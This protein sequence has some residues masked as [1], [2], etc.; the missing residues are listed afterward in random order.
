MITKEKLDNSIFY[1]PIQETSKYIYPSLK[2][3]TM[4]LK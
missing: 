3:G 1:N 4:I 2:T